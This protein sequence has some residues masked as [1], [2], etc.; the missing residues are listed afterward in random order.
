ML[1]HNLKEDYRNLN[2]VLNKTRRKYDKATPLEKKRLNK[3][4]TSLINKISKVRKKINELQ[5]NNTI[6]NYPI[7][8]DPLKLKPAG[9]DRV[10]PDGSILELNKILDKLK[11]LTDSSILPTSSGIL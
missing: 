3:K 6:A 11:Y 5:P 2:K 8:K 4:I 10:L 1:L 7:M 9:S